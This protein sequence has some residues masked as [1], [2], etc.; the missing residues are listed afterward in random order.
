MNRNP[1]GNGDI[2]SAACV[3]GKPLS[4][5]GIMGRTEA[6]G[7]GVYFGLKELLQVD[8]C[9]AIPQSF[10]LFGFQSG[11]AFSSRLPP[12]SLNPKKTPRVL[13]SRRVLLER[14]SSFRASEMSAIGLPSS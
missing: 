6:T 12:L 3:T 1:K 13:E 11:V 9:N 8:K 14:P 10:F 5:G 2:N 7:L 4:Q